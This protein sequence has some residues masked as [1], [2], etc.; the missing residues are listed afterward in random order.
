MAITPGYTDLLLSGHKEQLVL[1]CEGAPHGGH[2]RSLPELAD[3]SVQPG[4]TTRVLSAPVALLVPRPSPLRPPPGGLYVGL[5]FQ[6]QQPPS[7]HSGAPPAL[8]PP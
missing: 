7:P 4:G 3:P 2:S 8:P 6:E 5:T 1:P